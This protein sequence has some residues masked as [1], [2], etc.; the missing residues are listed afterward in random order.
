MLA[1]AIRVR[2]AGRLGASR[3]SMTDLTAPLRQRPKRHERAGSVPLVKIVAIAL[4]LFLGTFVLWAV[5]APDSS[6]DKPMAVAPTDLRIAKEPPKVVAVPQPA[7]AVDASEPPATAAPPPA[8]P[9]RAPAGVTVT[10]IDG[11]TG[12]K[13]EVVVAAPPVPPTAAARAGSDHND[14]ETTGQLPKKR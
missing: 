2:Q 12:A 9:V 3:M 4:G 7:A 14:A 5:M 8:P 1:V 6:G 10:I 13:R 11:K